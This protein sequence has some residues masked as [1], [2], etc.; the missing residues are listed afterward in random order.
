MRHVCMLATF[1]AMLVA[2]VLAL[3]ACGG[4]KSPAADPLTTPSFLLVSGM[5]TDSALTLSPAYFVE[6]AAVLPDTGGP[7][8]LEGLDGAGRSLLRYAFSP[9]AID[10]APDVA[11][12]TFAIPVNAATRDALITLRLTGPGRVAAARSSAAGRAAMLDRLAT[13]SADAN[14]DGSFSMQRG[15]GGAVRLRYDART[16]AG[17]MVRD[18]DTR[19]VLAFATGGTATF[20]TPK[21]A[22]QLVFSDG[23]QS[24]ARLVTI[25]K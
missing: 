13:A 9:T 15:T 7:F 3:A 23:V 16:W 11:Q 24:A 6:T 2:A 25:P 22:L 1:R 5:I 14:A 8:V 19:E 20:V 4:H 18:A 12:F 17:V 21:N 10:H